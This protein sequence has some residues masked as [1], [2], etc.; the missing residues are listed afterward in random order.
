MEASINQVSECAPSPLRSS[1]YS[2]TPSGRNRSASERAPPRPSHSCIVPSHASKRSQEEVVSALSQTHAS[3]VRIASCGG[4]AAA[5]TTRRLWRSRRERRRRR[6]GRRRKPRGTQLVGGGRSN[7]PWARR[8]NTTKPR[9]ARREGGIP[10]ATQDTIACAAGTTPAAAAA[11]PE[12]TGEG[13][14]SAQEQGRGGAAATA[15]APAEALPLNEGTTYLLFY[16]SVQ[17]VLEV[18]K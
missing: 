15:A 17:S 13:V 18:L 10:S 3:I 9:T 11:V 4:D 5:E 8:H 7:L 12:P 16:C 6:S 1:P 14:P 2:P